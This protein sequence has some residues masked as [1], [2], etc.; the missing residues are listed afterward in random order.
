MKRAIIIITIFMIIVNLF[1]VQTSA[2]AVVFSRIV[3]G[4]VGERVVAGIAEKAGV[5]YATKS[6][7]EKAVQKWN[8]EMY[9]KIE[10]Y[11]K[12]GDDIRARELAEFQAQ[13][14]NLN[15]R[16]LQ[17]SSKQGFGKTVISAGLFL[18]G[19][20]IFYDIK[21]ELDEALITEKNI[22]VMEGLE[23]I[24]ET[25]E[26]YSS[27]GPIVVNYTDAPAW[28]RWTIQWDSY[29]YTWEGPAIIRIQKK[30]WYEGEPISFTFTRPE[31]IKPIDVS[32]SSNPEGLQFYLYVGTYVAVYKQS[33]GAVTTK[34]G[35]YTLNYPA[36]NL[37]EKDFAVKDLAPN[38]YP[39][40]EIVEVPDLVPI[41][42]TGQVPE[43]FPNEIPIEI[44][45][46]NDYPEIIPEPWNDPLEIPKSE[47]EP[48][49]NP[50]PW[51]TPDPIDDPWG[52]ILP[53]Q[54]PIEPIAPPEVPEETTP[55]SCSKWD[56]KNWRSLGSNVTTKFP[57]SIPWDVARAFQAIFGDMESGTPSWEFTI[58]SSFNKPHTVTISIP[59]FFLE[60]QGFVKTFLL[61]TFDI[62]LIY[63]IRK[64]LG[65]AS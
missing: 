39:M 4:S 12:L 26:F 54:E 9:E 30:K 41:R 58:G 59:D 17:A 14:A 32:E 18:T 21:N 37:S 15:E 46:S 55:D 45:E 62:G 50:N 38:E 19:L 22:A 49:P 43:N 28:F 20:D 65:G 63:A 6:A 53:G 16:N 52:D 42:E 56:F 33:D 40:P 31:L 5:K 11:K 36:F 27:Y 47:P 64:W 57:F 7:R 51:P 29:P 1:P 60:W 10:H 25:G 13:L 2:N 61:I 24:Y 35:E 23:D 8:L 48:E 44:P 3:K 34:T